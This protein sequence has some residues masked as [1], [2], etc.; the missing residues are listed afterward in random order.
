MLDSMSQTEK[1]E[2]EFHPQYG[3][4]VCIKYYC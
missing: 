3:E 1:S 2:G 4:G